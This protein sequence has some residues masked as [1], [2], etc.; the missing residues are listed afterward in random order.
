MKLSTT[1]VNL[2]WVYYIPIFSNFHHS[3]IILLRIQ[4]FEFI[5]YDFNSFISYHSILKVISNIVILCILNFWYMGN[6]KN[7]LKTNWNG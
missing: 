5:M 3:I 6:G 7:M 4:I 1:T 2:I